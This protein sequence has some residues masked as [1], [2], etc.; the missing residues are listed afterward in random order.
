MQAQSALAALSEFAFDLAMMMI[1]F[2]FILTDGKRL[3]SWVTGGIAPG[4]RPHPGAARRSAGMV[5]RSVMGSNVLTG[6]AQAAVATVGYLIVQ[7][8]KPLFFGLATLLASFIPSVG[9]AIVALPLAGLLYL[10]GR[11]W[12]ALFLASGRCS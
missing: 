1:A 8:P 6:M 4:Q 9:T 11:P 2:F 3:V 7:A 5:T 10:M 12:A